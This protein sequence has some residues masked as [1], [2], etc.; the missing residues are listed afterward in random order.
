MTAKRFQIDD[1][2][3]ITE[4]GT[5]GS[6]IDCWEYADGKHW[7]SLCN[8]L[9]HL[10]EENEELKQLIR[11]VMQDRV[12]DYPLLQELEEVIK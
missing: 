8:K 2:G 12:V 4:F 9:N 7:E 10:Y 11:R 5:D 1:D 3:D 6:W